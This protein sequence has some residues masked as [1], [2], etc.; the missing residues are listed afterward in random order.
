[1]S[2]KETSIVILGGRGMLG[3]DL[4]KVCQHQ[5]CNVKVFDLPEFDITNPQQLQ[6]AVDSSGIIINCASYTNVDGAE[7]RKELANKINGEAVGRLGELAKK[8]G[9]WILHISTDFVFNGRLDRPYVET[10]APNP[11]STYG[12]SKLVGE[13]LLEQ[14]GCKHCIVRIQWTYGTAGDNFV[15]KI[16]RAAKGGKQLKIV[17][18]QV[19]SPTAT[20]EAAAAICELVPKRPEGIFHFASTGY[21][22]RYDMAKLLF[23]KL[24]MDVD[25]VPCK[26]SDYKTPAARPLNSRFDCSKIQALLKEPIKSWQI[27][28]ESF[29]RQL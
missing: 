14:S 9:K 27:P 4:V 20:S 1:M 2:S 24:S 11:V 29:L 17:E 6:Q 15:T 19:G 12:S 10:D 5:G 28:L 13:Q 8:A 3:T 21:V 16:I 22:S 23:D 26:T 25:M 7:S 18:D